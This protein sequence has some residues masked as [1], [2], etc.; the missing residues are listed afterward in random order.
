M[1]ELTDNEQ[2]RSLIRAIRERRLWSKAIVI[3]RNTV[4]PE[5]HENAGS[6]PE[7]RFAGVATLAGDLPENLQAR[8]QIAKEIWEVAGR[9][10]NDYEVWL[11]CPKPPNIEEAKRMW[12]D[13]PGHDRP[14]ILNDFVPVEQWV[15]LY[16][17]H[18][19]RFHVFCPRDA[20]ASV[21]NA[22]KKVLYDRFGLKFLPEATT[23]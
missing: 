14:R 3:A 15:Q 13:A 11:D 1:P 7:P 20:V 12:I 21:G 23:V 22:A 2:I 9:P 17:T 8:R 4:P 18:Q 6:S 10:C 16:G 19:S 5:M